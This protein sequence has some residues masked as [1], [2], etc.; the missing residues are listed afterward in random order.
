MNLLAHPHR[1]VAAGAYGIALT[2]AAEVLTAPYSS[3][4]VLFGLNPAVHAVKVVA[5]LVF[6]AGMLALADRHRAALGRVGVGAAV[7]LAAGTALGAVPYS[8]AEASL[9]STLTPAQAAAWLDVAYERQLAWIG[10]LA[11]AGM[12]L[13]LLGLVVLAVIVL[14]RRLLPR[15]RPVLSL[16]SMPLA[17][18]AGV[19]G[20]TT[21]L[22]VPHPPAWV[23]LGLGIA[24]AGRLAS[25]PRRPTRSDPIVLTTG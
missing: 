13:I 16:T 22:P 23:F 14:R 2:T 18:F 12:L 3:H 10:Y 7:A 11:S 20:G 6:I 19:L 1:V 21:D 4:V 25:A 5:A 17:V 8:V 24:Y 15:W 9:D